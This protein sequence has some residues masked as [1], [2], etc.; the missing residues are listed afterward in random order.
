MCGL[1][2][3]I[4]TLVDFELDAVSEI[5][6]LNN[7][8]CHVLPLSV[9]DN[10]LMVLSAASFASSCRDKPPPRNGWNQSRVLSSYFCQTSNCLETNT[11]SHKII[12]FYQRNQFLPSRVIVCYLLFILAIV[13]LVLQTHFYYKSIC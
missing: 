11:E 5:Q 13:S 12:D 4:H 6:S 7:R 2:S 9:D 3:C 8:H 10:G 1:C